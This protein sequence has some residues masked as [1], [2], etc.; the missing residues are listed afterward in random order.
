MAAILSFS[1][2]RRPVWVEMIPIRPFLAGDM[3]HQN[4]SDS[5]Q[6]ACLYSVRDLDVLPHRLFAAETVSQR[7]DL[8][9]DQGIGA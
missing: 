4:S 5:A 9:T 8:G 7:G 6:I 1:Q 3:T 2:N